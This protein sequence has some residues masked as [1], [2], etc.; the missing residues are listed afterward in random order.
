MAK[1]EIIIYSCAVLVVLAVF[2]EMLYITFYSRDRMLNTGE[3]LGNRY[4]IVSI[5]LGYNLAEKIMSRDFWYIFDEK[6]I[7]SEPSGYGEV[8]KLDQK[9]KTERSRM[10]IKK[11]EKNKKIHFFYRS[12]Y[13][14]DHNKWLHTVA[15]GVLSYI[16]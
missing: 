11:P 6:T 9:L 12:D 10:L 15:F 8:I 5:E 7:S 14:A 16:Y 13:Y 1:K 2:S 3:N 4:T